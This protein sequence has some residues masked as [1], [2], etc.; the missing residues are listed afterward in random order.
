MLGHI[1]GVNSVRL[2]IEQQFPQ[3]QWQSERSLRRLH[4]KE[5]GFHIPDGEFYLQGATYAVE[6]ELTPKSQARTAAIL[7]QLRAQYDGV[8]YFVTPQT[9]A[10][11]RP[12][13][14]ESKTIK[15]YE[16]ARVLQSP[17]AATS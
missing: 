6:V 17:P 3:G 7:A 1:H 14:G 10:L 2:R 4:A 12:L 5:S 13:V 9:Q 16:M 11:L 8:W 15:V